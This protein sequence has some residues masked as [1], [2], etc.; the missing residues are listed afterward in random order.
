MF[1]VCQALAWCIESCCSKE[2]RDFENRW[3]RRAVK[4][5]LSV[6]LNGFEFQSTQH[7]RLESSH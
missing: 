5:K 1:S 6:S 3:I 7:S 2:E 4:K